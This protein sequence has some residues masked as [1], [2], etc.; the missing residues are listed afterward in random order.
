MGKGG[1]NRNRV[2]DRVKY[3]EMLQVYKYKRIKCNLTQHSK[4]KQNKAGLKAPDIPAP[5]AP[6][7]QQQPV[8]VQHQP[9]LNWS[10]FKPEFS[11]KPEDAE[12]HLLRTTIGR[13]HINFK[14]VSRFLHFF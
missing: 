13:T 9:H 3:K 12:A 8:Q 10:H 6:Q 11:E 14:K 4:I 2:R 1:N 7:V 5:P